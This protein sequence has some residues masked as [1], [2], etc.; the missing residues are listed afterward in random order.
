MNAT[1]VKITVSREVINTVPSTHGVYLFICKGK[2]LYVGKSINLKVRLLSHLENAK[3]DPKEAAIINNSDAI[4]CIVTDSEFNALFL[5]SKLIK[6]HKPR[7]NRRWIDDKNYLYIKITTGEIYPKISA[8]RK[9]NLKKATYFGPFSSTKNVHGILREIRKVFPFCTQTKISKRPCF[10]SKI[11]QCD[12][13]PNKIESLTDPQE[14]KRLRQIYR[15]QLNRIIKVFRG[16][17]DLVLQDLY[18]ELKR[19]TQQARFEEAITVRNRIYKLEQLINHT[20]F[21]PDTMQL[22]N[23]SAEALTKLKELLTPY[24]GHMSEIRRI[25]CYDVSNFA[26][27]EATASMVVVTDGLI[28]KSQYRKFKI[29]DPLLRSDYDMM[30]EVFRRRLRNQWEKPDLIV[31][32]GGKPQVRT[33]LQTLQVADINIPLIGI[34]KNPDRFVIGVAKLSTI[35]PPVQNV[36]FRLVQA[37]RDESHRFAKKFHTELRRKKLIQ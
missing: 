1:P 4:E 25:E 30:Q 13:C 12:P 33:V 2:I 23:Q 28:D 21:S 22:P 37:L 9:E 18:D 24:F 36:G 27:K 14:K 19:L 26:G 32:D 31:V 11:H 15:R 7:Y 20:L 10:Y 6:T 17:T 3:V 16:R 35:K 34:A 8:V 29:K 5:E